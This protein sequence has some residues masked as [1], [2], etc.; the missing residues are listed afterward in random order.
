MM[1]G[2]MLFHLP[3]GLF[4]PAGVTM[5]IDGT[6]I[7]TLAIQ[8]CD[9]KGCYAGAPLTPDKIAAMNKGAKLN[10]AFQT[11]KKQKIVVP[12]AL[13]GFAATYKQL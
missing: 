7:E 9:A 5:D 13:K 2:A 6:K 8:T 1:N 11:L 12:V 10:V 3:H 4:I